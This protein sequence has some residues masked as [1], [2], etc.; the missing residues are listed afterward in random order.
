MA[1]LSTPALNPALY[2]HFAV[3]TVACTLVLAIF[4]DGENRE[5]VATEI[6]AQHTA[7]VARMTA[8]TPRYGKPT[9]KKAPQV[10]RFTGLGDTGVHFGDPM[11]FTGSK[12]QRVGKL[13][14]PAPA[15]L[16]EQFA[17]QD[18]ARFG[19]SKEELAALS[20]AEREKLLARLR[21]GG[22]PSDPKERQK[23]IEKLLAASAT[24]SGSG[25]ALE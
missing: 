3:L 22:L 13:D 14:L 19:I 5:A 18:Y 6:R 21:A 15:R 7:E 10:G 16:G 2:R 24:R 4:S 17:P 9:L 8:S 12:V 20:P 23:M 25:S 11:D 1:K